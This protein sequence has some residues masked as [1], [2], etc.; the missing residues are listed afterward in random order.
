M[1]FLYRSMPRE[2][3]NARRVFCIAPAT[4]RRGREG[5][6]VG[7]PRM[8]TNTVDGISM[9]FF[10][11]KMWFANSPSLG[12]PWGPYLMLSSSQKIGQIGG[13]ATNHFEKLTRSH[14]VIIPSTFFI[15]L[16]V[17]KKPCSLSI[18]SP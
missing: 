8:R 1:W 9:P 12:R 3:G 4:W 7:K 17:S 16:I 14:V 6:H 2:H 10:L 15:I 13:V 18:I 11:L 5:H